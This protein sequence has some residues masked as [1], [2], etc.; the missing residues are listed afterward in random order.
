M[1]EEVRDWGWSQCNLHQR[2]YPIRF[3]WKYN[4]QN[5]FKCRVYVS[6]YVYV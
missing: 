3:Y 6:K 5:I 4:L 1:V 2:P